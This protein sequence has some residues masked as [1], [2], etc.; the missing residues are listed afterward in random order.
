MQPIPLNKISELDS[1]L[2]PL[3]Y[4]H[5][6]VLSAALPLLYCFIRCTTVTLL[7]YP[8]HYRHFPLLVKTKGQ[9][10]TARQQTPAAVFE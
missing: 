2:Y 3:H 5:F 9:Q 10:F 8:L 6:I 4:R 7:L 1:L